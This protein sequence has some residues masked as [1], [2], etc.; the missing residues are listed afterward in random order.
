MPRRLSLFLSLLLL[1]LAKKF[2]ETPLGKA[3][4][5]IV[6]LAHWCA[7]TC[8]PLQAE[9]AAPDVLG[10]NRTQIP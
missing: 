4:K 10:C 5:T 8:G 3:L 9:E 2:I 1:V 6:R 7:D